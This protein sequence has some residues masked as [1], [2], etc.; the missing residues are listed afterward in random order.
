MSCHSRCLIQNDSKTWTNDRFNHT[1][2][3]R[4]DAAIFWI[5]LSASI[6]PIQ[7]SR[8]P[9]CLSVSDIDT[10]LCEESSSSSLCARLC[11]QTARL[12]VRSQVISRRDLIRPE[13]GKAGRMGV[14]DLLHM[15]V[16]KIYDVFLP[17]NPPDLLLISANKRVLS[18][19]LSRIKRSLLARQHIC[20]SQWSR[21]VFTSVSLFF[22][23]EGS[24]FKV[25]AQANRKVL[26][27]SSLWHTSRSSETILARP[28]AEEKENTPG[29]EQ[30]RQNEN[31]T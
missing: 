1:V 5:L 26:Q 31:E 27:H 14:V 29:Q 28:L 11:Q 2:C 30:K 8:A 7:I 3:L 12:L 19:C 6:H 21:A 25:L 20:F 9:V 17:A 22:F 15:N 13:D 18:Q 4:W 10:L 23:P 24:G 16:V